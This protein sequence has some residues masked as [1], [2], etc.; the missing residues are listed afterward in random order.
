MCY[1]WMPEFGKALG[2]PQRGGVTDVR[3]AWLEG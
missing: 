1:D 2:D 3:H